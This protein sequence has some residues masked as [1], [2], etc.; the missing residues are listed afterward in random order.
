MK[1]CLVL[2]LSF[3]VHV[4]LRQC[5]VAMPSGYTLVITRALGLHALGT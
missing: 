4:L 2:S 3:F 1:L 5:Y